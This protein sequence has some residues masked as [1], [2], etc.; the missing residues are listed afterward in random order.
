MISTHTQMTSSLTKALAFHAK[1]KNDMIFDT[2]STKLYCEGVQEQRVPLCEGPLP[3]PPPGRLLRDGPLRFRNR[4]RP[5]GEQKIFCSGWW[6]RENPPILCVYCTVNSRELK[7]TILALDF[8]TWRRCFLH[9][10]ISRFKKN[11][12]VRL[13][14]KA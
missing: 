3:L 8:A 1:M 7:Y 11:V 10:S 6:I 2:I 9:V 5:Q 12:S 4:R 14:K 13:C